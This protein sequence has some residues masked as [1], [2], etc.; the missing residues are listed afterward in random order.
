[1]II[2]HPNKSFVITELRKERD[3]ARRM[4]CFKKEKQ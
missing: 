3:K 1:M 4:Y 2:K